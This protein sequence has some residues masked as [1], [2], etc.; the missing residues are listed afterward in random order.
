MGA[1]TG[2]QGGARGALPRQG[3]LLQLQRAPLVAAALLLCAAWPAR[4]VWDCGDSDTFTFVF[5]PGCPSSES[6]CLDSIYLD[7]QV[8][9]TGSPWNP[10]DSEDTAE[11]CFAGFNAQWVCRATGCTNFIS[12]MIGEECSSDELE[13]PTSPERKAMSS[14]WADFFPGS[15][16]YSNCNYG[17]ARHS[18]FLAAPAA[19]RRRVARS[20]EMKRAGGIATDS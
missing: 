19:A 6:D 18:K 8:C 17:W 14:P 16:D 9:D 12:G 13:P 20:R 15:T 5:S 10:L 1:R 7:D 2:A 3:A 4:A 11:C